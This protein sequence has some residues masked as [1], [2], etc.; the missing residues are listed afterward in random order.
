M[1]PMHKQL[2]EY[3]AMR[4]ALGFA[5]K[6]PGKAL[7]SFVTFME[8]SRA[9]YIT[10]VLA[11]EWAQQPA[12]AK[13][14]TWAARLGYVRGF[15][16]YLKSFDYRTEIPPTELLPQQPKRI[17]PYIYS[18]RE[19][20]ALMAAALEL[21]LCRIDPAGSLL[22]RQTY[23]VLIGLLAVTG[24][25]ISEVT[26]LRLEHADLHNGIITVEKGKLGKSR[27][28]PLHTSTVKVLEKYLAHRRQYSQCHVSDF[29]FINRVGKHLDQGTI[30]RTFY[31]LSNTAGIR[32]KQTSPGGKFMGPRIHDLRHRFAVQTLLRWYRKGDDT[33]QRLPLLSTYLGHVHVNDTY[34]Y[35][36]SYPELMSRGVDRLEKRWEANA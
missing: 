12:S 11:L 18:D 35:L 10:T 13:H 5:L 33:E 17:Q 1:K 24:M 7:A 22:K 25:R 21:P 9:E 14:A 28:I 26:D 6:R 19:V 36:T 27:L 20:K 16:Q 29:F 8:Q 4:R 32:R 31:D 2:T 34:W 15:A 3:L 30:R 23:Y